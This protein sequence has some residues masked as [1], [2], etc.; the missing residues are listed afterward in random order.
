MIAQSN[1]GKG[2]GSESHCGFKSIPV[3]HSSQG[4]NS[5]REKGRIKRSDSGPPTCSTAQPQHLH[6]VMTPSRSLG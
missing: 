4:A 2:G 5:V 3:L 6:D 1:L